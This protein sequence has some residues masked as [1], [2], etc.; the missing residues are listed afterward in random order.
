LRKIGS[1]V[2]DESGFVGSI[3]TLSVQARDVRIAEQKS[4]KPGEPSHLVFVGSAILGA[5]TASN[6]SQAGVELE[7][8]LDD[9]SF[10]APIKADLRSADGN[11]FDLIWR[12]DSSA[13]ETLAPKTVG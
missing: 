7:M 10:A 8:E 12:R 5:A 2:R 11:R 9:P 3:I 1:F 6:S 4:P 13:P